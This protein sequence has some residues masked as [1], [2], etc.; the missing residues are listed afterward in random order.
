MAC[1]CRTCPDQ[2]QCHSGCCSADQPR[3]N[4]M[5]RNDCRVSS[6]CS[7]PKTMEKPPPDSHLYR[8]RRP[9][10]LPFSSQIRSLSVADSKFWQSSSLGLGSADT[11]THQSHQLGGRYDPVIGVQVSCHRQQTRFAVQEL[12]FV[13]LAARGSS[14]EPIIRLAHQNSKERIARQARL[15]CLLSRPPVSQFHHKLPEMGKY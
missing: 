8:N 12:P 11:H 6:T 14:G 1:R 9:V 10:R 5:I 4:S 15:Y 3:S 7:P 2:R 13:M